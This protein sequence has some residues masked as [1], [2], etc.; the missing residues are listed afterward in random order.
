MS[1]I[2]TERQIKSALEKLNN[3]PGWLDSHTH[4]RGFRRNSTVEQRRDLMRI[5]VERYGAFD[6]R[7]SHTNKEYR[8]SFDIENKEGLLAG[9]LPRRSFPNKKLLLDPIMSNLPPIE[10]LNGNL[11][12]DF[13]ELLERPIDDRDFI[14]WQIIRSDW[15]AILTILSRL[16][17]VD[18]AYFLPKAPNKKKS[19]SLKDRERRLGNVAIELFCMYEALEIGWTEIQNNVTG[20]IP[21]D[22]ESC[23][24]EIVKLRACTDLVMFC[25]F[26][27]NHVGFNANHKRFKLISANLPNFLNGVIEYGKLEELLK[28][29]SS[30]SL[31]KSP[32]TSELQEL[33]SAGHGL[34]IKNFLLQSPNLGTRD[35]AA[36]WGDACL[37]GFEISKR[38][39]RRRTGH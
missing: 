5:L 24:L 12:D 7:E 37:S 36:R 17:A 20:L 4:F 19:N 11:K 34:Q 10:L 35:K 16:E 15:E 22:P 6:N 26:I 25:R 28:N 32:I 18:N 33:F 13:E 3:E 27:P 31:D 23:F 21:K 29:V 14:F 39:L 1:Y 30:I 8:I 2:W 9:Y 38:T